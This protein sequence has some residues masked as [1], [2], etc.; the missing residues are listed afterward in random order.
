MQK[1]IELYREGVR[2]IELL[3]VFDVYDVCDKEKLLETLKHP[4]GFKFFKHQSRK[5]IETARKTIE[6]N[7]EIDI[8]TI[9]FSFYELRTGMVKQL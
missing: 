6:L 7:P 9:F 1:V 8:Y 4:K 5:E 3:I 2:N